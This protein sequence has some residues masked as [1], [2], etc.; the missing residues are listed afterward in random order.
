M[1]DPCTERSRRSC[2]VKRDAQETARLGGQTLKAFRRMRR[3]MRYCPQCVE[4]DDCPL[5][6][7]FNATVEQVILELQ[8]EWGLR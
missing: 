6:A 7:E 8:E 1:A 5:L 4:Y 2:P 3:R